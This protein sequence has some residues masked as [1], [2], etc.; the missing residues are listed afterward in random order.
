MAITKNKIIEAAESLLEQGQNPTL[1]SV[2]SALGSGSYTTISEALKGW[3]AARAKDQAQA[4][5][6]QVPASVQDAMGK[7]AITVWTAATQHH[8]SQLAA[9]RETLETDRQSIEAEKAETAE[10]ADQLSHDLDASQAKALQ[11][12]ADL[13]I[14]G[15]VLTDSRASTA[16]AQAKASER[17][18]RIEAQ[19]HE[20]E[21]L[22]SSERSARDHAVSASTERDALA[23]QLAAQ[24]KALVAAEKHATAETLRADRAEAAAQLATVQMDDLQAEIK[25]LRAEARATGDTLAQSIADATL[26]KEALEQALARLQNAE[27]R[28]RDARDEAAELRGRLAAMESSTPAPTKKPAA[29]RKPAASKGE[30]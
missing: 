2:R 15:Q 17:A 1:A 11:L 28:E 22:R 25:T 30:G 10:L 19:A 24:A 26:G 18:D 9:E 5:I 29:R 20:L 4:E 13:E 27:G 16:E 8:A 6:V 21:Q 23:N 14:T 7:A 12:A 3:K